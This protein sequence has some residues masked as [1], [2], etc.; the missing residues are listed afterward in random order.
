MAAAI[1][2]TSLGIRY[3]LRLTR[4]NTVRESFKNLSVRRE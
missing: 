3:N 4:K 2:V 1:D